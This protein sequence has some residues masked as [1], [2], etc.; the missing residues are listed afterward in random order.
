FPP[1]FVFRGNK[2][3]FRAD[4]VQNGKNREIQGIF[5][6]KRR[7]FVSYRESWEK[8]GAGNTKSLCKAI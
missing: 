5:G 4:A 3:P 2:M 8:K 7:N 6:E 1:F